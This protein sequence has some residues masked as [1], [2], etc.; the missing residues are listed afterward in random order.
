MAYIKDRESTHI[1]HVNRLSKEEMDSMI[2]RCVYEEP[3]YCVAECPMKLDT[4]AVLAAAAA[5]NFKKALSLYE[6]ITPFPVILSAGCEAPCEGKCKLC[7]L[8]DGIAIREVE[9]AIAKYGERTKSSGVFRMRKKKKAVIFGS[10]LLPLFL[11]GELERKMYPTTI[12]CEEENCSAYLKASAAFLSEE[13]HQVELARLKSLDLQFEFNCT[14]TK[15][16]IEEKKAG[17]DM[18]C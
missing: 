10:G 17:F 11:A 5:G 1:Y 9:R 16:F 6:K 7:Q 14:L 18:I 3:A 2:S 4:R 8:G 15:E 13:E 12:F